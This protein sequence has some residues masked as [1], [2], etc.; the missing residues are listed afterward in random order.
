MNS[1][2]IINEGIA[3][4]SNRLELWIRLLNDFKV[5]SVAEIGVWKGE[6]SEEILSKCDHIRKYYMVD[7][8]RKLSD[9]NKPINIEDASFEKVYEEAMQK[10]S[11]AKSKRIVLRGKTREVLDKIPDHS[12]DFVYL[13]GDHTLRGITIDLTCLFPKV[14]NGGWIGGDDF[15]GSPWEHG[16]NFEPTLVFP[17]SVYFAEAM[18]VKMGS[19]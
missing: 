3:T 5:D 15:M 2:M 9:W 7:P 1:E 4:A 11:F 19:E 10:T 12:L 14:K 8:W 17:F 6:F 13:D 16:I 18:D